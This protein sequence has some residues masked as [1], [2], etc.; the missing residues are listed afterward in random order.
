[1]ETR[2]GPMGTMR[3]GVRFLSSQGVL[4][5]AAALVLASSAI[6]GSGTLAGFQATTTNAGNT[7]SAGILRITNVSGANGTGTDCTADAGGTAGVLSGTCK[8]LINASLRV[9][10][11]ATSQTVTITNV[12][13]VNGLLSLSMGTQSSGNAAPPSTT[14]GVP[15]CGDAAGYPGKLLID[16]K[17]GTNTVLAQ[18][19]LSGVSGSIPLSSNTFTPGQSATYTVDLVFDS[20]AGN[21]YQNCTA[22]FPLTWTMDQR[23]ANTS[24]SPNANGA[25][26]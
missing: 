3:K 26:S 11:D 17:Q 14:G 7:F 19:A 6:V 18:T 25:A 10:G 21:T 15:A 8:Q 2:I 23:A 9:P 20:T 16:I 22:A 12:G 4:L 24:S 5:G 1:M 13:T